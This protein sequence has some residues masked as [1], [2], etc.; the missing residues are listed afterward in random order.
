ML[1][2]KSDFEDRY[3]KF[4]H[5]LKE[6]IISGLIKPGEFILP[7]NTLSKEYDLSRVSIRKALAQLVEEG[8]IEKIPGKGNRVTIPHDTQKQTL[9]LGW[10]SD[11]YEIEIVEQIIER[12]EQLNPFIKVDLQVMPNSQYI[13]NLTKSIDTDNG[14]D[15]FMVSD[16]HFRQL[17]ETERLDIIEPFLPDHFDPEKDSYKKVFDMFTYQNKVLV[18]PFVFSPV[19]ICYNKKMFDQAGVPENFTM[20]TWNQLL[21]IARQNTRDLDGN[22]L[23]DQYGFCFSASSNR[24]PVFLLQ[25]QGRFMTD[26]RSKSVMNS[27]ENIEA[28]QYCVDLMYKHQVS[29]I[30]SH[31]SNDL[32]ENLFMRERA[33]M[34]LTTYYFMNEFRD[35]KIKWDIL[36]PPKRAKQ[37]TL[38]LGGGLGVNANST[39][40][41]A[42][43]ALISYMISTE[44]QAMLKQNGCTIPVLRFVAEDNYLLQPGVHPTHYNAFKD[45]MP[46]AVTMRELNVTIKELELIENEL[47]LLWANMETPEDSCKRIDMLLNQEMAIT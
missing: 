25:N 21:E 9:T 7:E 24:W 8:L 13:Y 16:Y 6:E 19:M 39:M 26:D 46:H 4:I 3:N 14:P 18:T 28:L 23:I 44:A 32:A 15:V 45:I 33:G 47:H 30:F 38:L 43:Q 29:P 11:S 17:V 5:E 1:K 36:P 12:F 34:I 22:N 42:A 35:H 41:E 2:R 27:K 40:K 31:G 37:G 10:F 20:D